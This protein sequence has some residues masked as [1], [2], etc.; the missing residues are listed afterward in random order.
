MRPRWF[1]G[2]RT[3]TSSLTGTKPTTI[4]SK[5]ADAPKYVTRHQLTRNFDIPRPPATQLRMRKL[6]YNSPYRKSWR[7]VAVSTIRIC[8]AN[9][10]GSS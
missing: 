5:K 2:R 3:L 8:R 1:T 7:L 4:S 9:A 6:A 10:A